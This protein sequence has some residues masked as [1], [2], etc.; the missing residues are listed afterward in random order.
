MANGR[1]QLN[2]SQSLR[3][4]ASGFIG[5]G[6]PHGGMDTSELTDQL[7][8]T[9]T[10]LKFQR[11]L[12]SQNTE[13]LKSLANSNSEVSEAIKENLN[14]ETF[15]QLSNVA[16]KIVAGQRVTAE[17]GEFF[18]NNIKEVTSALQ[19]SGVEFEANL[20][21]VVGSFKEMMNNEQASL[22]TR[23]EALQSL[24]SGLDQQFADGEQPEVLQDLKSLSE[25]ELEFS[26]RQTDRLNQLLDDL[27]DNTTDVKLLGTLQRLENQFDMLVTTNQEIER[28]L[29][30]QAGPG[31]EEL[32][33]KLQE[34]LEEAVDPG[35]FE[36]MLGGGTLLG[37]LLGRGRGA[38][39]AAGTAARAAGAARGGG[40]LGGL[41]GAARTLGR[42]A[43]IAGK[44]SGVLALVMGAIDFVQGF[45]NAA[46]IAGIEDPDDL[47]LSDKIQ[48]GFASAISG[49]TFGLVDSQTV[50]EQIDRGINFLFGEG[51]GLLPNSAEALQKIL[52]ANPIGFVISNF[53]RLKEMFSKLFGG[54]GS[55]TERLGTFAED[56]GVLVG[57]AIKDL[58]EGLQTLTQ[59]LSDLA[60][61]VG[62]A[63]GKGIQMLGSL[64]IEGVQNLFTVENIKAA[65]SGVL[66]I[67]DLITD[68]G[69]IFTRFLSGVFEGIL[70]EGNMASMVLDMLA[71][72]Q[73]KIFE[74]LQASVEDF[75]LDKARKAMIGGLKDVVRG[76]VPSMGIGLEDKVVNA[77]FG[78]ETGSE[79]ETVP[80]EEQ[81]TPT[82]V[83]GGAAGEATGIGELIPNLFQQET[84]AQTEATQN[85][86]EGG[87]QQQQPVAIPMAGGGQ[88]KQKTPPAS[89]ETNVDDLSLSLLNVGAL[90]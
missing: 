58:F 61:K 69:S 22:E 67:G 21:D 24:V 19:N 85:Q 23:N 34:G 72:A 48:A 14:E 36:T 71:N 10:Q 8:T 2:N 17:Q 43:K 33:E 25:K 45:S 7:S 75:S 53:D 6:N 44:A 12:I 65:I 70:G 9:S 39:A 55:F 5:A 82:P 86:A 54:E 47:K 51:D 77:L 16:D 80:G 30:S 32:G 50:F 56:F 63:L 20:S 62:Q 29:E 1:A 35:F 76:V 52:S 87:G 4:R 38:G 31:G 66:S 79:G 60:P 57:E 41:G 46:E 74:G 3:Q 27:A 59:D 42:G 37:G 11:K 26:D 15:S 40:L 49:L 68:I 73:D 13:A 90:D 84:T 64:L 18:V 89:R 83:A 78:E 28:A 81:Q 88:Q